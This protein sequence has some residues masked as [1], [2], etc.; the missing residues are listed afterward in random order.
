MQRTAKVIGFIVF[1]IALT[2]GISLPVQAQA[3]TGTHDGWEWTR[4]N[5]N[6]TWMEWGEKYWPTKPVRGG[7][8]KIA[9]SVYIGMMNPNHWPVNDWDSMYLFYESITAYDGQYNQQVTWLMESFE[10]TSPTT[11][12]M[13]LQQGVK[14]HDGTDRNARMT[15]TAGRKL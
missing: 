11:L 12:I 2:A 15:M 5:L 7:V 13:K 3:G 8:Y 6:P 14:F 9:S 4:K 10:F 1:L